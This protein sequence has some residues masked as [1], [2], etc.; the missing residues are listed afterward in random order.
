MMRSAASFID[1]N[2]P[3][4]D[5]L[6]NRIRISDNNALIVRL[7]F[8]INHLSRW[9]TPIHD[10]NRLE[11]A[12]YRGEPTAKELVIAMRK[13]EARIFP[14]MHLI[15][16]QSR[17]NLDNLPVHEQ[18]PETAATDIATPTIVLMAQFRRLRQGTC[19]LLRSLPDDAWTLKGSS[20]RDTNASVRELA[21]HLALHDYRS[22]RAMDRTLDQVGA[23]EGLAE[24]QKTHL[25][26][27]LKLV[28]DT[29]HL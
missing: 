3:V 15:S 23:R 21:E 29:L 22:L 25:D 7:H 27:L 20:R 8:T 2:A 13:E 14:K 9:L 11:R 16:T 10:P 6:R 28:P 26:D 18:D 17:P 12:L 19:S 5:E 4:S 24:I 1:V